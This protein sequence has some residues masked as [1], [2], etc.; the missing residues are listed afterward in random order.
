MFSSSS[1]ILLLCMSCFS[2]E[3]PLS[4]TV[5]YFLDPASE[6]L[7]QMSEPVGPAGEMLLSTGGGRAVGGRMLKS[8]L[9]RE[10]GLQPATK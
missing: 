4:V 6:G 10:G 7:L 9:E 2:W 5:F 8:H 1:V 3:K